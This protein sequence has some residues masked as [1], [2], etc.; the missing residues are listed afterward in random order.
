MAEFRLVFRAKDFER[1]V[2]FYRDGLGL[3]I[4]ESWD[5]GQAERGM[6]FRAA[7]GLV[8]V[9]GLPPGQAYTPPQGF[10]LAFE[11]PDVDAWYAKACQKGLHIRGELGNKP[12]GH[13]TFSLNDPDG[14]KVIIYS[15]L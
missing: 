13:R 7:D 8:E 15:I 11:V 5:R 14:V 9:L 3:V 12:W 2:M 10:E 6:V 4:V 1:A